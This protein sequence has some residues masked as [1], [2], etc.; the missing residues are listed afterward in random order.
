VLYSKNVARNAAIVAL[1]LTAAFFGTLSGVIFAYQEDLPEISALDNYAPSTITRV[2]G[3]DGES[4]VG[5]FATER[6]LVIGYDDMAP[7]L[8]NAIIAAEDGGFNQHFGISISSIAIRATTEILQLVRDRMVGRRSRPAGASTLTQQLARN[9]LPETVG[10]QVGVNDVSLERK[11]KEWL[12]ALQIEK[13]YTKREIMTFYANHMLFG[14]GTYGVEAASRLYFAKSAKDITLEE[15]ALLAGILQL[16]ARQSPFVNIEAARGRR[17]YALQ[18]MADEGFLTQ[19]EADEAKQKPVIVQER[20][21]QDYS[22]APHYLENVRQH[23]EAR[24]G[25]RQLYES[26][27]SV[28][29]TLDVTLQRAANDAIARGLRRLD[30]RRGFRGVAQNVLADGKTLDEYQHA[31]WA[32]PIRVGDVVPAVVEAVGTPAPEGAARLRIVHVRVSHGRAAGRRL[33]S[34]SRAIS[35]KSR[36]SRWTRTRHQRTF[37]SSRRRLSKARLSPSTTAPVISGQWSGAGTSIAASSIAPLRRT[38]N[39][40]PLSSRSSLPQRSIA[41]IHRFRSW[42]IWRRA[43]RATSTRSTCRRTTTIFTKG[44]SRCAGPS[45]NP[46][47]FP[48]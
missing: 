22:V 10:F 25:A 20:P 32:R 33:A 18:R 37:V 2:Y 28:T 36:S 26:G 41:A 38:G 12:V 34:S 39:S 15:A 23:L 27:L 3:A 9:I 31:R 4:I 46:G 43:G 8:R 30:K 40:A 45:S 5:E 7:H 24:Y 14:H 42:K 1:F 48:Q 13:R 44:L 35:S 16:P 17:N 6:R 47:I 19:A 29:T 21:Q 11:I